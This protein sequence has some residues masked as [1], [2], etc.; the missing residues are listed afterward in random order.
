MRF[1]DGPSTHCDTLI[2]ASAERVWQLVTDIELPI[3]LSPELHRVTWLDGAEGPALGAR[4]EG[5]NR[6]ELLGDWRTVSHVVELAELSAF[7]WAVTDEDGRYGAPT[8]DPAA[9]LATWRF[10]LAPEA[11][12]VRLRQSVRIGPGNSGVTTA[13]E[14]WP[15]KE[16][17]ILD[18]RLNDLRTAMAANLADIKSRAEQADR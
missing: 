8:Q 16:E 10:D 1:T 7:A 11:D 15:D 18:F 2:N 12:G 3:R 6:S 5:H 13:I 17:Y 9:A 4:F 14:R